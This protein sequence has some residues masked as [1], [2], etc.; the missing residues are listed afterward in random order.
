MLTFGFMQLMIFLSKMTFWTNAESLQCDTPPPPPPPPNDDS[1]YIPKNVFKKRDAEE[2]KRYVP[3][4]KKAILYIM[5]Q[6]HKHEET[7]QT[8]KELVEKKC[9]KQIYYFLK[10]FISYFAFF[11]FSEISIIGGY[12][13]QIYY[14]FML[15]TIKYKKIKIFFMMRQCKELNMK[16]MLLMVMKLFF[17]VT[18]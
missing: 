2:R 18:K 10:Y 5:Q 8:D 16:I 3:C 12:R 7:V 14:S 11:I 6:E 17:R 9:N 15:K 1:K 4:D 13:I